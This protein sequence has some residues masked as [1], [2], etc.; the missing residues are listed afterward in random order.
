MLI[1]L[2]AGD[3][4]QGRRL[5]AVPETGRLDAAPQ[6]A[7]NY[8]L[9]VRPACVN[10]LPGRPPRVSNANW[11]WRPWAQPVKT[12]DAFELLGIRVLCRRSIR[13]T[14]RDF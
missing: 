9:M 3:L 8:A 1:N 14:C 10:V 7:L 12:A 6:E 2:P 5:A 11:R 13:W 4:M